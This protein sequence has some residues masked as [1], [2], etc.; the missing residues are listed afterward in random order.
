MNMNSYKCCSASSLESNEIL[1]QLS[2]LKLLADK[3]RLR[4]LCIL[5]SNVHTVNEIVE[6]LEESQSL[7]SHHLISLKE[8]DLVNFQ[9]EGREMHYSLSSKGINVLKL[10]K[11]LNKKN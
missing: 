2:L 5:N 6:H 3:N 9:K 7:I 4:I 1:A 11:I 10:L 8:M